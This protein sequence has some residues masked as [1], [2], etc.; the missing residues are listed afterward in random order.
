LVADRDCF[1]PFANCTSLLFPIDIVHFPRFVPVSYKVRIKTLPHSDSSADGIR[2]AKVAEATNMEAK[3]FTVRKSPCD[4]PL[5]ELE[6]PMINTMLSCLGVEHRKLNGL[7]MRLALAA[8]KLADD[9]E[10]IAPR[11]QALRVWDEI[12]EDLWSHLQ[13]EDELVSWGEAHDA[14]P[15]PLLDRLKSERQEMRSLIATLHELS[16][17]LDRGLTVGDRSGFG[18][19][20]LALARTLDSHVERYDSG[21]MPVILRALFLK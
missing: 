12:R 21:V 9:A 5:P 10:A 6:V 7:D 18:R 1:W 8:S 19:T 13:I 4:S 11:E 14:I 2:L 3:N 17:G 15:S 16:L 20:L